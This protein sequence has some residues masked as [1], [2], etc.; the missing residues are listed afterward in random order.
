MNNRAFLLCLLLAVFSLGTALELPEG[1]AFAPEI[2][3]PGE[4]SLLEKPEELAEAE[5]DVYGKGLFLPFSSWNRF[6]D[7]LASA[8]RQGKAQHSLAGYQSPDSLLKAELNVIAGYEHSFEDRDYGFLYKGLRLKSTVGKHWQLNSLWWNGVFTGNHEA[9]QGSELID[10]FASYDDEEIRLDNMNGDI[11]YNARNLCL[12]IGRGTFPIG[13]SISGSIILN[14][15]VNDYGYLLA[16]GRAGAFTLSFL[17]GTLKADSLSCEQNDLESHKTYPDKYLAL[18]QLSYHPGNKLS[19]FAGETIIYGN[20]SM[21]INYLLPNMFWRATEHNLWDRDN[22][23]IY[24]GGKFR[25]HPRLLLYAQ[26]ALDE[27]KYREL[28]GNWWGNKYALQG[29][30]SYRPPLAMPE[31]E[32]LTLGLEVTGVRPFTYTHYMN[33]TMT[34]HDGRSLGYS[35]GSNVWDLSLMLKLPYKQSFLWQSLISAGKYGSFGHLYNINYREAFPGNLL[36]TGTA[37]WFEGEKTTYTAITN[38]M[39]IDIFAHHR[40]LLSHS[41]THENDWEHKLAAAWQF[42]Y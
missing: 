41:S 10:G 40:L 37:D 25:A 24:G 38:S 13:N 14:D 1:S 16:E 27:L 32:P 9:A 4:N 26:A 8:F 7:A 29:G 5:V 33:H 23:L 19:L 20:R 36:N 21:D 39:L 31:S 34:S 22:V 30:L 2:R 15:N 12:A 28:L 6:R 17:H 3:I 42:V 35:K 11:S 18:H